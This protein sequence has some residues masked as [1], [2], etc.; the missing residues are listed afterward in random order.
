VPTLLDLSLDLF[1][2]EGPFVG[3]RWHKWINSSDLEWTT[4]PLAYFRR[5]GGSF[6]CFLLLY[7]SGLGVMRTRGSQGTNLTSSQSHYEKVTIYSRWALMTSSY[8]PT[9]LMEED[10]GSGQI[11]S[12]YA[13]LFGVIPHSRVW[14]L[15]LNCFHK[16]MVGFNLEQG[17]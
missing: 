7:R 3:R 17:S 8:H 16:V 13:I 10:I 6:L 1:L 9:V 15:D 14:L 12:G 5:G 4:S 2:T 11:R